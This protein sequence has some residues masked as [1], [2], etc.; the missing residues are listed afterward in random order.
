MPHPC[1]QA[2]EPLPLGTKPLLRPGAEAVAYHI[3][4][5]PLVDGQIL[6]TTI[7]LPRGSA[8]TS[9]LHFHTTHAEYLQL[10]TGSIF[11]EIENQVK[12]FSALSG[13]EFPVTAWQPEPVQQGLIIQIPRYARHNWGRA[14]H[15]IGSGKKHV[16]NGYDKMPEDWLDEVVVE[17]W[18]EPSDLDKPLFFWNLN[19][20]I[21]TPNDS[22]LPLRQSLTRSLLGEWWIPF[23][24]FVIFYEL[25]NWPVFF[26]PS[27]TDRLGPY[28]GD[29]LGR[30]LEKKS[31]HMM[32]FAVLFTAKVMAWILRVTAVTRE[33]TP[34]DL[35][36]AYK[37]SGNKGP[38]NQSRQ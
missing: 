28:L 24:L 20:V 1:P 4:V 33:R 30:W 23:Q 8:W 9:G 36:E 21:T 3:P 19:R 31:E 13:G 25:D 38:R 16:L 32:T 2:L 11:V 29:P 15:Y 34:H 18:T 14:E 5:S 10:V 26:T 37:R 35:W 12:V 6:K 22:V 7:A 17:E 27:L